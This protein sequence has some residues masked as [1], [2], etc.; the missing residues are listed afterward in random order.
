MA[1]FLFSSSI[2]F[3][4]CLI[5]FCNCY[6]CIISDIMILTPDSTPWERFSTAWSK[7]M[8][9]LWVRRTTGGP[10]SSMPPPCLTLLISS[11]LQTRAVGMS[12]R[13]LAH[14]QPN[15]G[16]GSR[17]KKSGN[18]GQSDWETQSDILLAS[19]KP[20]VIIKMGASPHICQMNSSPR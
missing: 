7:R 18:R 3:S 13:F 17:S 20:Q 14:G 4:R 1:A 6:L 9:N 15:A 19:Q 2:I 11:L 5:L 8:A 12:S 16:N 10:A